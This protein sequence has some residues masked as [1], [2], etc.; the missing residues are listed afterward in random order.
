MIGHEMDDDHLRRAL[1]P[2]GRSRPGEEV[3]MIKVGDREMLPDRA[4]AEAFR[5]SDWF[6]WV[7]GLSA[8]NGLLL[9]FA[10]DRMLLV[11]LGASLFLHHFGR[12]VSDGVGSTTLIPAITIALEVLIIGFFILCGFLARRA[13]LSAIFIGVAAYALDAALLAYL[14]VWLAVA[15]HAVV[16]FFILRSLPFHFALARAKKAAVSTSAPSPSAA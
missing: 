13:W 1:N 7:A 3:Q 6:F 8:V 2:T 4:K 5:G 9:W 16:L 11:G 14:Q 15:L 12:G 10:A